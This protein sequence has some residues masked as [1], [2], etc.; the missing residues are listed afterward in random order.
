MRSNTL[1]WWSWLACL[2]GA[3]LIASAQSIPAFPGAEGAGAFATGGRPVEKINYYP[4]SSNPLL[5]RRGTVY[6]V[7]SLDPDPT[8]EIEGSLSYGLKN[9]NFWYRT[10]PFVEPDI[11]DPDTF[12][13]TPRIIV[14]DVGGTINLGEADFTPMN[15][16]L[17]GQTAPG[18]ITIYGG[19]FNPGHRVS[20]D[21]P[22]YYP[23]KTNNLVLRNFAIRTHDANEKDG[24]WLATTNSIAD[25]LSMS[26]YTD[27]GVSI[28]DS[29]RDITVQ[30]S[31]IGPGW[32]N[33]DGDGSQ[34]EGSTS[35][36]DIS[37]H[38]NLYI[39]NDARIP[40]LGEK[41]GD[42]VEVDF[43][44]NVIF[45]WND[46][47]AGYGH[48]AEPAFTNFVNNYYI[49][50][51]GNS[52]SD[53][54]FYSGGP[55][56]HIFQSGNLLDLD[57]DGVP[58]GTDYGWDRFDGDE[59]QRSIP[60]TVPHGVTQTATETLAT[61]QGYVGAN[62]WDRDFLDVRVMNQLATFG[63]GTTS[64]TG[65][66][67]RTIDS[68]D[69]DAVVNAPLQTRP[70]GW[71]TDNDGMPDD[72]ETDHGLN[73]YS[74]EADPDWNSDFDGDGYINVEEYINEIAE[75]PAPYD[76]QWSAGDSR[77]EEINNWS[78]THSSPGEAPTTTHW[79]PSKFDVAVIESGTVTVD[80]VGQHAGTLVLG[81]GAGDNATLNITAGWLKVEHAGVAAGTG[82][83]IIGADPAATAQ[84]NLSGGELSATMLAKSAGGSFNF[85]GGALHADE[86]DF[87]LV[88]NGGTLA[89]GE[90]TGGTMIFGNYD[91][92]AGSTLEIEIAAVADF[93]VVAVTG[94]ADLAGVVNVILDSSFTLSPT[95]EFVILVADTLVDSGITLA[96]GGDNSLFTL[97]V[98][99]AT[100]VLTLLAGAPGINGDYNDDGVVDAA[101]YTVWRDTLG[102]TTD[103]RA[104]GD[105]T[106]ASAGVIDA[107]DYAA[108]RANFGATAAAG[109]T[110]SLSAAV[111]EP[112]S[113]A[114][115]LVG[116][117]VL[118]MAGRRRGFHR[119]G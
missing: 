36:A 72:W 105:D 28:T 42:G 115:L 95:D 54:I 45:N 96:L 85:T 2:L 48:D 33:P 61:V 10:H 38:H 113:L 35:H 34:L 66:V 5:E 110:Q 108:W 17:A 24:L 114:T 55:G 97:D 51:P 92:L 26:W 63:L 76:I 58:D 6:H 98:D 29:A 31:I 4:D 25:H 20:W 75:W 71:D 81:A 8:G 82:T 112:A 94:T 118:L 62:W 23:A 60:Y 116:G 41:E 40:R 83:V 15:F 65:S 46:S 102:S 74:T 1:V 21:S 44:N 22:L 47:K 32:N 27:E 88:N 13:V 64:E 117:L 30:H 11:D 78:I 69:V 16:T 59:T 101:D 39:H 106:G 53:R 18:G 79:Q 90:G 68:A 119:V 104:N 109:S 111:P 87:D 43:R 100:G 49:G 9:E 93:D 67:L 37:V 86:V 77:Y 50:G 57:R 103:L 3:P 70:A 84:L 73:P 91:Q 14:F 99:T 89:P 80:S 12:D 56:Q 7:T 52:S 107:A 19:E